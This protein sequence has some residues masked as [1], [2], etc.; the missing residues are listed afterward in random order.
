VALLTPWLASLVL[1][2]YVPDYYTPAHPAPPCR[3]TTLATCRAAA[4]EQLRG[5][6]WLQTGDT[7]VRD[8]PW[9]HGTTQT[10]VWEAINLLIEGIRDKPVWEHPH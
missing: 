4:A 8:W 1:Y 6:I 7:A 5:P 3:T 2:V 9:R 10:R